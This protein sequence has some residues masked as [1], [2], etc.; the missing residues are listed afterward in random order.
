MLKMTQKNPKARKQHILQIDIYQSIWMNLKNIFQALLQPKNS[1]IWSKIAENDSLN[2]IKSKSQTSWG[3]AGSSSATLKG[4]LNQSA[5]FS[6]MIVLD[7]LSW[8]WLSKFLFIASKYKKNEKKEKFL[9]YCSLKKL[10][11]VSES[12]I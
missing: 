11:N 5:I 6:Y 8:E 2:T 4:I 3:W 10:S 12:W 1:P 9:C 7:F